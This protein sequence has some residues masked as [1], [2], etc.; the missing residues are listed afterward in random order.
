MIR[1]ACCETDES[2]SD[3]IALAHIVALHETV[4]L[5]GREE[6]PGGAPVELT[7]GREL[8]HRERLAAER[9]RVQE[10]DPTGPPIGLVG[11]RVVWLFVVPFPAY[12]TVVPSSCQVLSGKLT[13]PG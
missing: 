3:G 13:N 4:V 12:P 5:E 10:S 9:E 6:P 7:R 1:F 2:V 11:G 8:R